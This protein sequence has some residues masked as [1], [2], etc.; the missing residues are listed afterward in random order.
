MKLR[1]SR[2]KKEYHLSAHKGEDAVVELIV[3]LGLLVLDAVLPD[4][5][6]DEAQAAGERIQPSNQATYI[7]LTTTPTPKPNRPN[8]PRVRR[9]NPHHVDPL[10]EELEGLAEGRGLLRRRDE[11]AQAGL[12]GGPLGGGVGVAARGLDALD[13]ADDGPDEAH[14]G[15]PV[16]APAAGLL[17]DEFGV[18]DLADGAGVALP[19]EVDEAV[20]DLNEHAGDADVARVGDAEIVDQAVP[21]GLG[22]REGRGG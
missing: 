7:L 12:D 9:V 3:E 1:K 16:V 6:R 19:G 5:G 18:D 21:E 22:G 2:L 15:G 4:N 20:A 13:D 11:R 8:S 10:E 17:L 14:G